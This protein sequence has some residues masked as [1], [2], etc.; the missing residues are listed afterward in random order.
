MD[1][2]WKGKTNRKTKKMEGVRDDPMYETIL[3]HLLEC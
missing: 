3:L 1:W 2:Y